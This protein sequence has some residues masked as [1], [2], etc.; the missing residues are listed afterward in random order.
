MKIIWFIGILLGLYSITITGTKDSVSCLHERCIS[1]P[2]DSISD[3]FFPTV[4]ERHY[5]WYFQQHPSHVFDGFD[6]PVGKPNAHGYFKALNFGDKKHLGED[7]N[8]NGGGDTDLGD[9]VY[10]TGNGLVVFSKK[11]CCGWGNVI[12]IVHHRP[13]EERP[14]IET[15]YAHM[16]TIHVKAGDMVKRGDQIGTIGNASGRYSAHLHL[17]LRDFCGM[18]LGPGYSDNVF[19]YLDPSRFIAGHRP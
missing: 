12:R 13:G 18:S 4:P 15:V 3:D 14:F 17:E 16:H 5:A 2:A 6:Y 19:G 7:W 10:S 11:V 1:V 9:P 8:G